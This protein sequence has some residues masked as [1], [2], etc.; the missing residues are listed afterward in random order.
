M[1]KSQVLAALALAF[2]LGLGVVVP[3]TETFAAV[4]APAQEEAAKELNDKL[5]KAVEQAQKIDG[6]NIYSGMIT[7]IDD[8]AKAV[9]DESKKAAP[10]FYDKLT[11]TTQIDI[12]TDGN[13]AQNIKLSVNVSSSNKENYGALMDA[14]VKY[15][16][17]QVNIIQSFNG[18]EEADLSALDKQKLANARNNYAAITK[19]ITDTKTS[20]A[21]AIATAAPLDD[22]NSAVEAVIGAKAVDEIEASDAYKNGTDLDKSDLLVAAGKADKNYKYFN[23]LVSATNEANKI[24]TTGSYSIADGQKALIALQNAIEGKT[25]PDGTGD[26]TNKPDDEKD[27]SAPDTGILSNTEASASTTLAMVAGIATALTAAGAGVVAYR[28]ARRSSRK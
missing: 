21:T 26:G 4:E 12:A 17:Q 16:A 28:N 7:K 6:Y 11:G 18:K 20:I 27:P 23:A 22:I 10:A 14:A 24:A 15:Q 5:T 19:A 8:Y 3:A 2:A 25:V 1:K 9:A 13:P